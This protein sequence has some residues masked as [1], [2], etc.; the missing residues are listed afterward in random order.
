MAMTFSRR[1][2]TLE[3]VG[4][5]EVDK[6]YS[7]IGQLLVG[8]G[9]WSLDARQRLGTRSKKWRAKTGIRKWLAY[10]NAEHPHSP[11]EFLPP[12]EAYASKT[13]LMR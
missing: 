2:S 13:E 4:A 8:R 3:Q 10:C 5:V 7:K 11:H 1:G 6:L 12:D 9:F